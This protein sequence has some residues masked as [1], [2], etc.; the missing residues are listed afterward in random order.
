MKKVYLIYIRCPAKLYEKKLSKHIVHNKY[1]YKNGFYL[2]LYA[3]TTDK[4][5]IEKFKTLR[6][7]SQSLYTYKKVKM[8]SDEFD[9]FKAEYSDERLRYYLYRYNVPE[10]YNRAF[11]FYGDDPELDIET[12]TDGWY[13]EYHEMENFVNFVSTKNEFC[14]ATIY[15]GDYLMQKFEN[16]FC[17]NFMMFKDKYREALDKSGFCELAL[18][19]GIGS[20]EDPDQYQELVDAVSFNSSFGLSLFGFKRCTVFANKFLILIDIFRELIIGNN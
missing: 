9:L 7:A 20:F 8:D 5:K 4:E 3:W 18:M 19:A 12:I 17:A 16:G 2:G 6:E 11:N 10:N 13:E 1:K 14:A 15:G